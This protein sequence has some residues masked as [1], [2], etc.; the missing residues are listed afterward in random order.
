MKKLILI[1]LVIIMLTGCRKTDT[2][3]FSEAVSQNGDWSVKNGNISLKDGGASV[4]IK[5]TYIGDG[6]IDEGKSWSCKVMV[7]ET[8]KESSIYNADDIFTRLDIYGKEMTEG[9]TKIVS[10]ENVVNI[11]NEYDFNHVYLKIEYTKNN[12]EYED[13]IELSLKN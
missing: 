5:L 8:N 3:K 12:E 11:E 4:K 6:T 9:D 7:C 2:Y 13:N 1:F 10:N